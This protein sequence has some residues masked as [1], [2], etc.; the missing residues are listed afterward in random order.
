M[1][2][3]ASYQKYRASVTHV[4]N[5]LRYP[6][7]E[8]G[9]PT[10]DRFNKNARYAPATR[11]YVAQKP[12]QKTGTP[13]LDMKWPW[14]KS[15]N[16]WPMRPATAHQSFFLKPITAAATNSAPGNNSSKSACVEPAMIANNA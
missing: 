14:T 11:S 10:L 5:H 6:C 9:P 8:P 2:C 16:P 1:A 4:L 15:N 12:G 13:G 3:T 7:L